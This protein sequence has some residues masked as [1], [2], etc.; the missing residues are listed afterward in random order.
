MNT[1]SKSDIDKNIGEIL[2]TFRLKNNLTQEQL[3]EKLGISLKYI[4][5]IENGNNGVKTQTLINYINILGITPNT[6]YKALITNQEVAENIILSE[7]LNSLSSEKKNFV[8]S[9]IDLLQNLDS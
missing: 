7:K 6:I 2:K 8:N 5:R 4:S 1:L 9:I 3:A